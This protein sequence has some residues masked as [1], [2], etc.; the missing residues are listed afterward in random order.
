MP[1][2]YIAYGAVWAIGTCLTRLIVYVYTYMLLCLYV[3]V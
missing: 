1:N 3:C 2:M